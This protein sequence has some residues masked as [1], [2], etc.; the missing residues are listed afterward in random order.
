MSLNLDC[1]KLDADED[2]A[3]CSVCG[4]ICDCPAECSEYVNFF[5]KQ[6]Y[7]KNTEIENLLKGGDT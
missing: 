6:P 5:G 3:H 4:Y 7:K 1:R 2:K